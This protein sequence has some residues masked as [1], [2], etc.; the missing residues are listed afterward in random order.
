MRAGPGPLRAA[1]RP[2]REGA[3]IHVV[4]PVERRLVAV[5]RAEQTVDELDAL[6]AAVV[7]VGDLVPPCPEAATRIDPAGFESGQDGGER[8]RRGRERAWGSRAPRADA[9]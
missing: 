6:H 5:A 3:A 1:P 9:R 4:G 8:P 7:L 2:R